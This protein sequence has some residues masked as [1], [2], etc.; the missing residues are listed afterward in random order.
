M[1]LGDT[2]SSGGGIAERLKGR[3]GRVWTYRWSVEIDGQ[4]YDARLESGWR[5]NVFVV[6]S[7]GVEL[8]REALDF[9]AEPFRLQE[10]IVAGAGGQSLSFRTAPRTFYS[11]GLE[12][13]RDGTIV[14]QSH[15]NPFGALAAVQKLSSFGDSEEAKERMKR[16]PRPK[17]KPRSSALPRR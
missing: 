15:P 6:S 10:L 17:T 12:V 16:K 5:T 2:S 3:L 8:A 14:H 1:S 11:Y 4:R 9:Y 13:A 7:G